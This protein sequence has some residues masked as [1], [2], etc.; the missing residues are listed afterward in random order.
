[1]ASPSPT[2]TTKPA[3][4]GEAAKDKDGSLV[5]TIESPRQKGTTRLR[6]LLPD[7]IEKG[8]R[9]PVMYVLPVEKLDERRFGDGLAEVRRLGLHNT[10]KLLCVYPTFSHTPW[11]ADHPT[12]ASLG[13]ESYLL[14]D[15]LPFVEANYPALAEPR[16]RL[17]LGFSKSGWGAWSLLLRHPDVFGKAAAWD[18][19][20]TKARP[21]AWGMGE[22]FGT[23]ENFNKYHVPT[24]LERVAGRLG[25]QP[26]LALLGW[27]NF[28][29]HLEAIRTRLLA[30]KL[31]HEYRDGPRRKH[32]WAGGW[33]AEAVAFLAASPP[34][35]KP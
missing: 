13:Q 32:H 26:R 3:R 21:D 7:G 15:V 25:P 19:P 6:I 1:M 33:V 12:D 14:K 2:A 27:G 34:E 28:R 10:H 23:Q 5:H 22:V 30:L 18:A 31:P 4:F 29:D 11:Y 8:R 24:L 17:L 9:C 35:K 20:L 16:G